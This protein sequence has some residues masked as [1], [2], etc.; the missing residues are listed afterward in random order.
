MARSAA[1][2]QKALAEIPEI[3]EEFWHGVSVPGSGQELN[4]ALEQAGRVADFLEFAELLAA[5]ALQ[6]DESCGAHFRVEHQY[7]D[8]EA[9][10]DDEHY[11]HVSAWEYKGDGA[12]PALHE[13]PLHWES[14][15][16][17]VRSY[18]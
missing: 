4:L 17:S 9:K 10:R 13:E 16:P 12:R 5:D 2:L 1:S 18:K 6:R 11:S 7:P 15:H 8:G 14:V 3:R